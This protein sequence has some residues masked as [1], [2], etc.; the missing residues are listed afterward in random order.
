MTE[1]KEL[2]G[3]DILRVDETIKRDLEDIARSNDPLLSDIL[4]YALLGGGKRVRPLL[5][6][7]CSR[8]CGR[9]DNDLYRLASSF[10][11]LHVATLLHDDVIDQADTRRGKVSVNSRFGLVGAILAGDFLHAYSMEIVG[12]LGGQRALESF[13]RATRGMVDGEFVQ[14]RNSRRFNQSEQ[15]YY[16]VIMGK[17]ALLIGA[18]CEVGA[19]YGHG[20]EGAAELLGNYGLRL[21]CGFQ[22]IDDLLD[23]CGNAEKTGKRI[24]NDLAE[25]KMT[26]PLILAMQRADADGRKRLTEILEDPEHRPEHFAEVYELIERYD[27]FS[28]SKKKAEEMISEAMTAIDRLGNHTNLQSMTTLKALAHYVLTR[29]K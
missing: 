7:L 6:I 8:I 13:T 25:K 3:S 19:L 9:D 26:L 2:I 24:G 20:A 17:T 14:L 29:D 27:G 22:I 10:E 21:G 4:E 15:D 11:Y 18:A 12:R 28:D 23:Y 5:V 16:T 1:L